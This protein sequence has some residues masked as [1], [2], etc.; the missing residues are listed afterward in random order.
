MLTVSVTKPRIILIDSRNKSELPE[1]ENLGLASIASFLRDN[2]ISVTLS[3]LDVS[4]SSQDQLSNIKS[5]YNIFGFSA[6]HENVDFIFLTAKLIKEANPLAII[7]VGG[8]FATETADL[9][10][11]ACSDIDFVVLG[12]GE[13][14]LLEVANKFPDLKSIYD[15]KNIYSRQIDQ[16]L[17][18]EV[19]KVS[20]KNNHWPTAH[21]YARNTNGRPS[22]IARLYSKRGCTCNCTFCLLP[23]KAQKKLRKFS[24]RP[25]QDL[26]DEILELNKDAG[27]RAFMIHDCPFDDAGKL[28]IKRV[29]E[30]CD[31]LLAHNEIFSF[32]CIID[33]KFINKKSESLIKKMRKAGISQIMYLIGAGNVHDEKILKNQNFIVQKE[34]SI[35]LFVSNDIEVMFEFFNYNPLSTILS[36]EENYNFLY[37]Q[38]A[39][40]LDYFLFKAPVYF[41]S[42]LHDI[43]INAG[44]LKD[45]YS[46]K[47]VFD[48]KFQEPY[49][50]EVDNFF[51]NVIRKSSIIHED[52]NFHNYVYLCNWLRVLFPESMQ[53]IIEG[54]NSMKTKLKSILLNYFKVIMIDRNLS[55]AESTFLEFESELL[56]VYNNIKSLQM[57]QIRKPDIRKYLTRN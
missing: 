44:L 26:F 36:F 45:S 22:A 20:F 54:L 23:S 4:K 17:L 25:M 18:K 49:F 55:L 1:S 21:D 37:R 42:E 29:E 35:D 5:Q 48:Y 27:F 51:I 38:N 15:L 50:I 53:E 57:K 14:P 34:E 19:S 56:T 8:R 16:I 52:Y 28:G 46:Y 30:F 33:G 47:N 31:I 3:S 39:Y 43:C 13:F 7:C 11:N 24:G 12:D 41:G 9:I 40:V 32:E 6:F 10:L 2:D